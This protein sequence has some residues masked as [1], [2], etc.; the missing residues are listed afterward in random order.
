MH[1]A[2]GGFAQSTVY[3]V[4]GRDAPALIANVTGSHAAPVCCS[5]IVAWLT[6]APPAQLPPATVVLIARSSLP[7]ASTTNTIGSA[8]VVSFDLISMPVW[9][10]AVASWAGAPRIVPLSAYDRS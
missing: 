2:V 9:V 7:V 3:V 5:V 8:A 10:G 4:A 6:P 1:C